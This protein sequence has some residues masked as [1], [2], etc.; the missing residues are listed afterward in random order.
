M[1]TRLAFVVA[2]LGGSSAF[3]STITQNTSWTIDRA[4]TSTKYRVTAYGDSIFAGYNGGLFS[5]A[6]RAGPEVTGEYAS[7]LWNTDVEVVR[8]TKSGAVA[9]DI[10]NNK[11]VAERSYMQA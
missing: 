8:R 1:L 2:I 10:Y 3:A 7:A 4:G 5:V 11:I 6:R 9:S